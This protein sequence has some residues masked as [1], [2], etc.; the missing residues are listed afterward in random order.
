MTRRNSAWWLLV[1]PFVVAVSSSDPPPTAVPQ[2]C[3]ALAGDTPRIPGLQTGQAVSTDGTTTLQFMSDVIACG[4]WRNEYKS[5]CQDHWSFHIT[6]PDR[7]IAPGTYALAQLG[8]TFGDLFMNTAPEPGC[9]HE[10]PTSLRGVGSI[11]LEAH[12]ATLT[13][14]SADDQC[15]TGTI[16][17]LADPYFADAPPFNGAFFAVRCAR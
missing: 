5:D 7:A 1:V 3:P 6:I 13:I 12:E 16:A 2:V 11:G 10:C 15:I 9:G 14:H 4:A 17:G 8:A